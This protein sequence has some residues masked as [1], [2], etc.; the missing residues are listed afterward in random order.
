[1][2]FFSSS[3]PQSCTTVMSR[4]IP[5]GSGYGNEPIFVLEMNLA[6][7]SL[8]TKVL[9]AS[10]FVLSMLCLRETERVSEWMML[11]SDD[12]INDYFFFDIF[13][14]R[15][16]R[17]RQGDVFQNW[18]RD[19]L[20]IVT[21][22]SNLCILTRLLLLMLYMTLDYG[23]I[24]HHLHAQHV[25]DVGRGTVEALRAEDYCRL[26][27]ADSWSTF[28]RLAQSMVRLPYQCRWDGASAPE[29]DWMS[30]VTPK[31]SL[32]WMDRHAARR[33]CLGPH[34]WP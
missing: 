4:T 5:Y 2:L 7:L 28:W 3:F 29:I 27:G 31:W 34:T 26:T 11:S 32:P 20:S 6:F 12:A 19:Q 9:F 21:S 24:M 23:I 10:V 1:M 13:S 16:S 8:S 30:T 15:C 33:V 22:Y 18:F 25:E 14:V 17:V